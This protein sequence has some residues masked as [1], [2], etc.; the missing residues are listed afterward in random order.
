MSQDLTEYSPGESALSL[1]THRLE[2]ARAKSQ[3]DSD[4][5]KSE[6]LG[7]LSWAIPEL[8]RFA[9][10]QVKLSKTG[11]PV[12][13]D[14]RLITSEVVWHYFRPKQRESVKRSDDGALLSFGNEP[15][16]EPE[17][18]RLLERIDNHLK[19]ESKRD[20]QSLLRASLKLSDEEVSKRAKRAKRA[21]RERSKRLSEL[22][23]S[24]TPMSERVESKRLA[25]TQSELE[26]ESAYVDT[27]E[28]AR[29]F[30]SA[31]LESDAP[32]RALLKQEQEQARAERLALYAERAKRLGVNVSSELGALT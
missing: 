22:A 28:Y 19:R 17:S 20:T 3:R 27:R 2:Q 32:E 13:Q 12:A 16:N 11:E 7:S 23:S 5:I 14:F 31:E 10:G 8:A 24:P 21:K 30:W 4:V 29:D 25:L 15:N 9:T 6:S 26:Q 1:F 18:A